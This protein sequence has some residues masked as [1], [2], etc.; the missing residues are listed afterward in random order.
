MRDIDRLSG[1]DFWRL[2]LADPPEL[3]AIE[4][5]LRYTQFQAVDEMIERSC[6]AE[7]LPKVVGGKGRPAQRLAALRAAYRDA[8]PNRPLRD[9][10][11]LTTLEYQLAEALEVVFPH[12]PDDANDLVRLAAAALE[13]ADR[14]VCGLPS[15]TVN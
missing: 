5:E 4:R 2:I 13:A 1:E 7:S 12:I 15:A 14:K 9:F 3:P 11:R 6:W 8:H 10:T